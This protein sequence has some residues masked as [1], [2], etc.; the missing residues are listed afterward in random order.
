[1]RWFLAGS[2]L[3]LVL[4]VPAMRYRWVYR[5]SKRLREVVPGRVYRSGCLSAAGLEEAIRRYHL[6]TVINLMEEDTDPFL[7][8]SYFFGGGVHEKELCQRLGV[9]YVVIRPDLLPPTRLP[10]ERPRAIDQFLALL[11][12]PDTYPVLW[13]CRAGLHR[14]GVFTAI[15]RM[16]YQGWTPLAAWQELKANGFGEYNCFAD[17]PYITQYVLTYRPGL[18]AVN[19]QAVSSGGQA[20]CAPCR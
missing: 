11:D 20:D 7:F 19:S 2:I 3:F 15:Y 6:R 9:R 13:H 10:A 18:R 4:V 5:H 14:T 17:N 8:R 1:M 16:E 12:D